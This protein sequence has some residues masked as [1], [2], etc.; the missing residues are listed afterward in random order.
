MRNFCFSSKDRRYFVPIQPRQSNI[1]I[2]VPAHPPESPPL[3]NWRLIDSFD[4][5]WDTVSTNIR[6]R[7][8]G[9][10]LIRRIFHSDDQF[11]EGR[12]GNW[13]TVFCLYCAKRNYSRRSNACPILHACT[14]KFLKCLW[15]INRGNLRSTFQILM[16]SFERNLTQ[17]WWNWIFANWRKN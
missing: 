9:P 2:T 7:R 10:N 1:I 3:E 13:S 17:L 12:D 16:R 8:S 4:V 14:E 5:A 15:R 11:V 6:K